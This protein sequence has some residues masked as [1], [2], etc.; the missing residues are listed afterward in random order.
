MTVTKGTAAGLSL[1]ALALLALVILVANLFGHQL[2]GLFLASPGLDKV[3]HAAVY[4][5]VFV[6][7]YSLALRMTGNARKS[8]LIAAAGA[9]GLSAGDE[10]LQQLAPGRS[11]ELFDL[12]AGWSGV[13]LGWLAVSRPP[14]AT[15]VTAAA[16][17]IGAVSYVTYDTHARL[18]DYSRA[19]RSERAHDFAGA[20]EHY[21]RALA[22][23]LHTPE[24]YNGLS[25]VSVESGVGNPLD[26]VKYG[27]L[28]LDM[29][30][31]DADMLDTYGW[32]LHHAG[33][34]AEALGYLQ[35]SFA[36]KPTM[37]CIHYHL[38]EVYLALA[39]P[40]KAEAHFLAQLRLPE[41]REAAM[42]ARA[43]ERT[44]GTSG[45]RLKGHAR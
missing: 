45:S 37:F 15:A 6:S 25:W 32:A 14:I 38:G 5:L 23:G 33:R 3:V 36:K 18:I 39:E 31:E 34:S 17:A 11:V 1:L 2:T 43:L 21:L 40:E 10:L 19:L 24:V 8:A 27:R 30:P 7:A 16:L 20:R 29:R 26:A 22:A 35:R 4:F 12:V 13:T 41:T 44:T 28:A 9:V 42:A